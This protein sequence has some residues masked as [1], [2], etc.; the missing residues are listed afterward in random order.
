MGS[1]GPTVKGAHIVRSCR[2]RSTWYIYAWR[3]GP[4]IRTAKGLVKP[5]LT[6]EDMAEIGRKAIEARTLPLDLFAGVV[7]AYR[8]SEAW[9]GLAAGTRKTWGAQLDLIEA[10]WAKVPIRLF[11]DPRMTPKIVAW[12]D[13]RAST[14]RSADMG[15]TVLS[16]LLGWARL[17]GLVTMN[18]ADGIPTIYRRTDRAEVIW[19]PHDIA[20][21]EAEAKQPLIDALRLAAFT[22]LRRADL[23]A[24]RWDEI[25]EFAIVRTASKKSRGKRYRVTVPIV[26]QLRG[27]LDELKT[28]HR[29][30]GVETVLVN[31]YGNKWTGDGLNSSFEDARAKANGKTG[32]WHVERHPDT[33]EE[34]RIAKRIHDFRG[35]FATV[36]LTLPGKRLTDEEVADMMGWDPKN[37]GAI[38][39]RYVDDSAVVVALGRRIAKATVKQSVKRRTKQ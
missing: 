26:P 39:K 20:A 10:K 12:R 14:P 4:K 6:R 18:A 17:R 38:R 19:L 25:G 29:R 8:K 22:G 21:I 31:S 11:S 13:G 32:I 2:D 5:K 1:T 24:L 30:V 23:V 27:L 36:L 15:V 34:E 28:R 16:Q 37:V 9:T 35:T 7:A 3:G 33:G